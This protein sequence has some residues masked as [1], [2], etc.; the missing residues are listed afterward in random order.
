MPSA[1]WARVC[2]EVTFTRRICDELRASG[3]NLLICV[4][5]WRVKSEHDVC[6]AIFQFVN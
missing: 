3:R 2:H 1:C 6:Y 5:N 4:E